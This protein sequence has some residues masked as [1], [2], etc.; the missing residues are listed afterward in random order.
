[1]SSSA[2]TARGRRS[3]ARSSSST[4]LLRDLEEPRR[5]ARPVGE[6]QEALEDAQEDLL[7]QVLREAPVTDE[8]QDVVVD[9]LLVRP[10]DEAERPLVTPLGL[11][12]HTVD[13]LR[14]GRCAAEDEWSRDVSRTITTR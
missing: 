8:P 14:Q 4:R 6:A 7:R 12:E 13:G 9:G 2:T 3:S 10:D 11:S 1:M 5:E